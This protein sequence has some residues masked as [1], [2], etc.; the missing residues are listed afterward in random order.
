LTTRDLQQKRFPFAQEFQALLG[1]VNVTARRPQKKD[2]DGEERHTYSQYGTD[3]D[4]HQRRAQPFHLPPNVAMSEPEAPAS[5]CI[6]VHKPQISKRRSL[7]RL[8]R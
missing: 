4:I 2:A 5:G 1:Q 6:K 8:L 3:A 7:G